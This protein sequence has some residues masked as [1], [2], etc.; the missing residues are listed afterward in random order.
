MICK[1]KDQVKEVDTQVVDQEEEEEDQLFMVTSFSSKESSDSWLIDSECTNHLTYDK[2][3]FEKLG[4]TEV[5]RVRID[6]G[7]HLEVKGK[8]TVAITSY[9]GTK[10]IP[11]IL[12]V[13]KIDQN[14]LSV[15]QL[16]D[17]GYKVLFE[18][19]SCLT[20]DASGKDLFNNKMKGKSFALNPTAFISRVSA[21]EIWHRRLK[22]FHHRCFLQMQLK[23]LVEEL[24]DIDDDMPPCR[25]CN[26][27]KQHRQPFPKQ[28]WRGSKKLQ[29]VHIDLCG[30]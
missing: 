18:N 24:A 17:K 30:P 23:K 16:L 7:E 12:F 26:F 6:N 21:T 19:K 5:K 8:G 15:G 10:F 9:E 3:F 27:G 29:L 28:A 22:H 25:A 4:D 20:K 14:L 1:T 13:P 2:E 11:Y